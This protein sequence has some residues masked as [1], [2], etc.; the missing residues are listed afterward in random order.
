MGDG[1]APAEL[2]LDSEIEKSLEKLESAGGPD[3]VAVKM[4][5]CAGGRVDILEYKHSSYDVQMTAVAEDYREKRDE[6]KSWLDSLLD[7]GFPN[8]SRSLKSP[9]F[10]TKDFGNPPSYSP[11]YRFSESLSEQELEEI[12]AGFADV[13]CPEPFHLNYPE[14]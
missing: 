3:F 14:I 9:D 6:T 12:K 7:A 1:R 10:T 13:F 8:T 11:G 2:Y 4:E 5:L